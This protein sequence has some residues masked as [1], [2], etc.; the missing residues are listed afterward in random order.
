MQPKPDLEPL[1]PLAAHPLAA[2]PAAAQGE[3]AEG[4]AAG[5]EAEPDPAWGPAYGW[6]QPR[7]PRWT[8][9][10][11]RDLLAA[12]G[13]TPRRL[14]AAELPGGWENLNLRLDADGERLVLRRYD[15]T[16]PAEARWEI[17]LLRFLTRRGFPTPPLIER[18]DG[19]AF[20]TFTGRPAALFAFVEG[21]HPRW[22]SLRAAESTTQAIASLHVLTA[23]LR[24]PYPRTRLDNRK[25]LERFQEWTRRPPDA[26][27]QPIPP[28]LQQLTAETARYAAAFATR[29]AE[30]AARWGPL[31]TGVVHHDAHGNNVL[32]DAG[33]RLIALLDF[34][35]GHET[36]LLT[37]VAVLLD[38][39]A[40]AHRD[41]A[42]SPFD[43]RRAARLL[44]AYAG[45]RPL[46]PAE[47]EL[48]PDV[49]V[50][51]NLADATSY[52][53]G[54][55]EQGTPA[56]VAIADCNQYARF[57]ERTA[58]P[59]WRQRIRSTLLAALDDLDS[60]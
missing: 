59:S 19:Q 32:V 14:T 35:D 16:A 50:L 13:R 54:R 38:A 36:F 10:E 60:E 37:D 25:R 48:L 27:P 53:T 9:D 17:E 42:D 28:A 22:D 31:P 49:M 24:L 29:L 6:G 20:A 2:A 18:L 34:D 7:E 55:I 52:I 58:A 15:V 51:Y 40:V 33:D 56:A 5:A 45:Q 3:T 46:T 21:R 47:W 57:R 43:P 11:V 41:S 4:G 8:L 30:A 12:Y 26:V 23:G 44:R 39:W 1:Q